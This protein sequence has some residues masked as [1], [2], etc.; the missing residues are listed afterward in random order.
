MD[1]QI[2]YRFS[3]LNQSKQLRMRPHFIKCGSISMFSPIIERIVGFVK[4]NALTDTLIRFHSQEAQSA[5]VLSV[6]P[7]KVL[8]HPVGKNAIISTE[9]DVTYITG[10]ECYL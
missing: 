8:L 2:H 10:P 6:C 9:A 5:N 1:L 4:R 7:D 3:G